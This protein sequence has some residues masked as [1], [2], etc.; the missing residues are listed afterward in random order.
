MKII[1]ALVLMALITGMSSAERGWVNNITVNEYDM[2]WSYTETFTGND[3]FVYRVGADEEFGSNDS[4][5]NAWELLKIDGEMRRKLRSSIDN[6]MDVRINNVT[7]GIEVIDVDAMLS[8]GI[9]GNTHTF[10]GVE[11][12]YRVTYRFKESIFN[13]GSIWFLGQA[14]SPVTIILPEG[15]DVVNINGMDNVTR[16]ANEISGFFREVSKDRGE[17]TISMIKNASFAVE[18]PEVNATGVAFSEEIPEEPVKLF[19]KVRD[20]TVIGVGILL[21]LLIYV[22]KVRKR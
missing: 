18:A 21:I 4:F 11:N 3:S 8:P 10:E 13:A 7:E 2:T 22:F 19:S 6:E 17:I 12:K 5:I 9:I 1:L 15:I 14:R 20:A 16:N